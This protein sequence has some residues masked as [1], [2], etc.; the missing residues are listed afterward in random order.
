[1]VE[2]HLKNDKFSLIIILLKLE[3]AS[4]FILVLIIMVLTIQLS[5]IMKSKLQLV[6]KYL[7]PVDHYH[8]I[9]V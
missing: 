2:F 1:M 6:T 9:M 5:F 4:I 8:I 7:H 3:H